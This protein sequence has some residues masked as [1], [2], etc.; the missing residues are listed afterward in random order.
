[1]NWEER[2]IK[3]AF[4]IKFWERGDDWSKMLKNSPYQNLSDPAPSFT[5][6]EKPYQCELCGTK[7][8]AENVFKDSKNGNY[9]CKSHYIIPKVNTYNVIND[10]GETVSKGKDTREISRK[11]REQTGKL[12]NLDKKRK[13]KEEKKKR[14]NE[15]KDFT[16]DTR[17][18]DA[19][20]ASIYQSNEEE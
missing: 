13:E 4:N 5:I 9:Y 10:M 14:K 18:L 11:V 7:Q 20:F 19:I 15:L 2:Y 12:Y 1:M 8:Y 3:E 17:P 16:K 6:L